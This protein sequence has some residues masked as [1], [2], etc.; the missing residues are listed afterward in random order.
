MLSLSLPSSGD[1]HIRFRLEVKAFAVEEWIGDLIRK[2]L[3][4]FLCATHYDRLLKT[5]L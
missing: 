1:V 3:P 2:E 4:L 5:Q